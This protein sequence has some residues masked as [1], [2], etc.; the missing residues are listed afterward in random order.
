MR[1]D[2]DVLVITREGKLFSDGWK[3]L[4]EERM[5]EMKTIQMSRRPPLY[6]IDFYCGDVISMSEQDV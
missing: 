4:L 5:V 6:M 1:H 2:V 3:V